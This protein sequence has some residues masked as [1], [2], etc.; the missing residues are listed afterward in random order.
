M[1]V[2]DLDY[3]LIIR[4]SCRHKRNIFLLQEFNLCILQ[5]GTHQNHT[6]HLMICNNPLQ[7]RNI[8]HLTHRKQNVI[9]DRLRHLLNTE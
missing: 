2:V 4:T 7:R 9:S 8:I 5:K 3:T 1:V 6:I